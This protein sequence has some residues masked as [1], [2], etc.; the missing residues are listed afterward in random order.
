MQ[1]SEILEAAGSQE[2]LVQILVIVKVEDYKDLPF[3]VISMTNC[4]QVRLF[5]A[6]TDPD[7][8]DW[9]RDREDRE[10]SVISGSGWLLQLENEVPVALGSES[11][12]FIPKGVWHRA[13]RTPRATD[14]LVRVKLLV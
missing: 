3:S 6:E 11:P 14:L 10:V 12:H 13:I 5:K 4:E 8:S 2:D 9:H 1:T 7:E